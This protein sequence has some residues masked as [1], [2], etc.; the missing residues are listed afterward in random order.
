[1]RN[2]V[3]RSPA[4]RPIP[5]PA[6]AR[7][8][9]APPAVVSAMRAPLGTVVG[10]IALGLAATLAGAGCVPARAPEP[11]R[12]I[13]PAQPPPDPPPIVA[14]ESP[15]APERGPSPA[16]APAPS[17]PPA[18]APVPPA[19]RDPKPAPGVGHAA[20]MRSAR[21]LEAELG[22]AAPPAVR[23]DPAASD[24]LKGWFSRTNV[25]VERADR[26]F[27]SAFAAPDAGARERVDALL[28]ATRLAANAAARLES[29]GLGL[30]PRSWRADPRVYT[31]F[32]DVEV[33]P[34]RRLRAAARALAA[35][36]SATA[37]EG[38]ISSAPCD[39]Y[40][41]TEGRPPS[42]CAC[43]PGDPLCT[44]SAWCER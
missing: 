31:T 11:E 24:P 8:L 7:E 43:D 12:A 26:A 9:R 38:G 5:A 33:G 29:S 13:V 44:G 32:E 39:R 37:R 2:I 30:L 1:M 41:Q 42:A 18:P 25:L 40:A 36:C 34:A 19:W 28:G 22:K 14:A 4:R 16:A 23:G 6:L 10:G 3:R 21:A 20:A 15:P 35:M 27:A 17:P